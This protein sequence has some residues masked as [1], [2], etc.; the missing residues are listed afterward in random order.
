MFNF[1]DIKE[2]PLVLGAVDGT[3]IPIKAPSV[4]EHLYVCRKGFHALV[5]QGVCDANNVFTNIVAHYAG[6]THDAHIWNNSKLSEAFESGIIKNGWLLGDS[7]YSL[8]HW[9][10]IPV[11]NSSTA[12]ERKYNKAHKFTRC[13]IERTFGIWKMRFRCI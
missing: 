2:F 7:G 3:L 11:L 12:A 5:V 4:D 13:V 10:L 8:K 9:L 1:Y 6:S